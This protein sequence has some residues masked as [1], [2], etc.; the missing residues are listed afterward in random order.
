MDVLITSLIAILL[1]C[2]SRTSEVLALHNN[3]LILDAGKYYIRCQPS[4]RGKLIVKP[5]PEVMTD[6]C[7]TAF[8]CL[9]KLAAPAQSRADEEDFYDVER[10]VK[11]KDSLF[12]LPNEKGKITKVNRQYISIFLAGG[13]YGKRKVV[14]IFERHGYT[15]AERFTPHSCRHLLNTLAQRANMDQLL[16]ALWSGRRSIAQ[17]QEYNHQTTAD[18]ERKAKNVG[19]I[20]RKSPVATPI[21]RA[22]F[23]KKRIIQGSMQKTEYGYCL[24]DYSQSPCTLL[25]DCLNCSEQ[26]CRKGDLHL[27]PKLQNDLAESE[28]L[29]ERCRS[30]RD[31]VGANRWLDYHERRIVILREM[32]RIIE[33]PAVEDGALI[34]RHMDAWDKFGLVDQVPPPAEPGTL[35]F[36][37]FALPPHTLM[38][39][40]SEKLDL[41]EYLLERSE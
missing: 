12:V 34:Y 10:G 29:I 4:K 40:P 1:C 18:Y 26:V 21:A 17:N 28:V 11:V 37:T 3:S 8:S 19:Y 2:P 32:M 38:S 7:R 6:I 22:E 30:D 31:R 20:E 27:L 13:L 39:T 41:T 35:P 16:I 24:H 23:L 15:L 25:R 36:S 5:V 33:D 14:S 9:E